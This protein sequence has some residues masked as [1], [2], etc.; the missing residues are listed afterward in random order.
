MAKKELPNKHDSRKNLFELED[1]KTKNA[2][3][4]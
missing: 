3:T 1:A 4:N 2:P